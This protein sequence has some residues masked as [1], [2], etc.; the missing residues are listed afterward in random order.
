[1]FIYE[2]NQPTSQTRIQRTVHSMNDVRVH[3]NVSDPMQLRKTAVNQSCIQCAWDD[4]LKHDERYLDMQ[5]HHDMYTNPFQNYKYIREMIKY[6]IDR[7]YATYNNIKEVAGD[8]GVPIPPQEHEE[9]PLYDKSK[10]INTGSCTESQLSRIYNEFESGKQSLILGK[11]YHLEGGYDPSIGKPFWTVVADE[12]EPSNKDKYK[13]RILGM[14]THV[15][16]KKKHQKDYKIDYE[17][18][19]ESQTHYKRRNISLK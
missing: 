9:I 17:P 14:G 12:K 11:R 7:S 10:F 4:D 15:H 2:K 13:I 3:Y 16:D 6:Y 5:A 1:M 8:L 18:E 19:D